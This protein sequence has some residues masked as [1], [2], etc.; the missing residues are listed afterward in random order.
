MTHLIPNM[1]L[2]KKKSYNVKVFRLK[3]AT[4]ETYGIQKN[5]KQ[6]E[7]CLIDNQNFFFNPI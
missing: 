2:D 7:I 5:N 4:V 3:Q 6:N 1:L